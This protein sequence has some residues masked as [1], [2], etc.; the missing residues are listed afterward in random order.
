MKA[1][2]YELKDTQC[3]DIAC[4]L[5]RSHPKSPYV[6][7]WI[8]ERF[9][10]WERQDAVR[11]LMLFIDGVAVSSKY[12]WER[13]EGEVVQYLERAFWKHRDQWRVQ[14]DVLEKTSS[15]RSSPGR[16]GRPVWARPSSG[17]PFDDAQ[18]ALGCITED[19]Q[20]LLVARAVMRR[21]GLRQATASAS[22]FGRPRFNLAPR[23]ATEMP[24]RLPPA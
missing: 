7:A 14:A 11:W 20:R 23:L 15:P 22:T 3:P 4:G 24:E 13:M 18:V 16:G 21:D 5:A 2:W 17:N 9:K 6:G 12:R 10:E 8:S 1:V 19:A